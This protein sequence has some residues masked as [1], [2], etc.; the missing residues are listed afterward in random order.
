M[1]GSGATAAVGLAG[2]GLVG[3]GGG[4]NDEADG[5][6]ADA[7]TASAS[8]QAEVQSFLYQR[9]DTSAKAT[10]GGI[11]T[12]Y[13]PGD[14]TLDPLSATSYSSAYQTAYIYPTLLRFKD[15]FRE[16]SK[17]GVEANLAASWEQPDSQTITFKL[18]PK[19]AWD[20]K[21][22]GR[23]IDAED[24]AISWTKYAAKGQTRID[25]ANSASPTAPITSVTAV[26]KSTVQFKLAFPMAATIGQL[27]YDRNLL[28]MPRES[29]GS[30]DGAYD[31]LKET[32]SGG[33][34]LMEYQKSVAYTYRRNPNY[35]N[36]DKVMLDGIDMPVIS[37]T[38]VVEAQFRAKKLWA[39]APPAKQV[40][41]FRKDMPD[42]WVDQNALSKANW[43]IYFGLR[44]DSP[45]RD[46]R[47]RQA[48]SML[49]DRDAY[50]DNWNNVTAL[51]AAGY[52]MEVKYNS[53]LSAGWGPSGYWVD[54]KSADMGD[55]AKSFS[56]NVAE[57][58]KLLTA[59]GYTSAIETD[60]NWIPE[61][62]YGTEFPKWAETFKGF[63]E[64]DGLFKLKQV[65][66]PYA[67]EYLPKFYWNKGDFNGI[68]VGATTDY[69]ADPDGHI[70]AY[71][72]SKGSR[73]KVAFKGTDTIDAKSD[74]MIDAQRKELDADKRIQMIRD[75]QKY[76]ATTMPTVPFPGLTSTFTFAWP[77][78]GNYGV[79]RNWDAESSR[80]S[81]AEHLW[82]DKS[83]Y[84]G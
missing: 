65:N 25:L 16:A 67:T 63:F 9:E 44:P 11:M 58:K 14:V 20:A 80:F 69:P 7:P 55:G 23:A 28:V 33:P 39:F 43:F 79:H 66:P 59:A 38:A 12:T 48:L 22:N 45:F 18:Q 77:W 50:L 29:Q 76:V 78:A 51:R 4:E 57:A 61:A 54:P 41:D 5:S 1:L 82:F 31:P 3:C 47:V 37:E 49:V 83:K 21:L 53:H 62:Y 27:A 84:N 74:A 56:L 42:A 60:I 30:G 64:A 36:A 46:A 6:I 32:R 24:V 8:K 19:A 81:Q 15:G 13:Y 73:Q 52:P 35:W 70:F 17:G 71:Y 10:K 26:D 72:H 75:W 34:W 2:L 40:V 68:T